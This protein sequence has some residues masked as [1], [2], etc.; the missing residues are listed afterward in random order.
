M[1]I[2]FK[3]EL[4]II[5]EDVDRENIVIKG[6]NKWQWLKVVEDN[7]KEAVYINGVKLGDL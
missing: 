7:F 2:R 4:E 5:P 3:G 1:W 6:D